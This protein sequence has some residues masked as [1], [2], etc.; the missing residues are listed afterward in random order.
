[1]IKNND[2]ENQQDRKLETVVLGGGCF[3][4]LDAVYRELIGVRSVLCGYAGG[5]VEF[6]T[7]EAV[8]AGHTGHAEV[9]SVTFDPD[10]ISFE[11]M[12]RVFFAI[13]DPTTRNRQGHDVGSQYRSIIVCQN[14]RQEQ[15]VYRVMHE[16]KDLWPSP[17]V[18]EVA[19]AAIFY[20]A[21]PEHQN[22]LALHPQQGY[23]QL[24]IAPKLAH[25]R[26]QFAQ[27]LRT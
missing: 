4:C 13:H 25:F 27:F 8:C 17:M 9:I 22:Y 23:C 26:Q 14:K 20:Q 1:M 16:L 18:T 7:Y 24:V 6:P 19:A 12:L 10:L 5:D 21:E 15:A 11:Q 2:K 3:W